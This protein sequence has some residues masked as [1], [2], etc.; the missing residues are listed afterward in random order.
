MRVSARP[1]GGLGSHLA[2]GGLGFCSVAIDSAP[3]GRPGGGLEAAGA[4]CA[5]TGA[6]SHA[7]TKKA[8]VA[9]LSSDSAVERRREAAERLG[10]VSKA[11]DADSVAALAEALHDAESEVRLAA[12]EALGRLAERG[13]VGAA[14]VLHVS[15][16]SHVDASVRFAA[17]WTHGRL[18]SRGDATS[19]ERH[20]SEGEKDAA[21]IGSLA[22]SLVDAD[23]CVR[24]QAVAMVPE[25]AKVGDVEAFRFAGALIGDADPAVGRAALDALLKLA[26][27]VSSTGVVLSRADAAKDMSR[28]GVKLSAEAALASVSEAAM[29]LTPYA[30]AGV[31]ELAVEALLRLAG[32]GNAVA[33]DALVE[34][35]GHGSGRVRRACVE[36]LG[37]LRAKDDHVAASALVACLEDTE[38]AVLSAAVNAVVQAAGSGDAVALSAVVSHAKRASTGKEDPAASLHGTLD[39]VLSS[40][41]T[42]AAREGFRGGGA[43]AAARR[44]TGTET[45]SAGIWPVAAQ[46][47]ISDWRARSAAAQI[48]GFTVGAKAEAASIAL[49]ATSLKDAD[50]HWRSRLAVEAAAKILCAAF[51]PQ[52]HTTA[53]L[54]VLGELAV[55]ADQRVSQKAVLALQSVADRRRGFDSHVQ[56]LPRP[57]FG[58]PAPP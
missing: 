12:A 49:A 22:S 36:C 9:R 42:A 25:V 19:S 24:A 51:G 32:V 13:V 27:V 7:L 45:A 43:P 28:R 4:Q 11:D 56:A 44:N 1:I 5:V 31:C 47:K 18:A 48:L 40:L 8:L 52:P 3:F 30:D 29:H 6:W 10:N 26:G 16:T 23:P 53:A 58:S 20:S 37:Q 15:R 35:L 33:R 46:L 55:E 14:D 54:C 2:R 21:G 39:G 50:R 38:P 57:Q 41:R 34:G 17:V